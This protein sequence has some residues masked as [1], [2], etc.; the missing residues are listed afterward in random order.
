MTDTTGVPAVPLPEVHPPA[1]SATTTVT[2]STNGA[3]KRFTSIGVSLVGCV[4]IEGII[5]LACI[6]K[7]PEANASIGAKDA[8]KR[9]RLLGVNRTSGLASPARVWRRRTWKY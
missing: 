8:G 7:P 2:T 9:R 1:T 4:A 3:A 6:Y 5:A